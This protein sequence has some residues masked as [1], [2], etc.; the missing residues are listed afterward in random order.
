MGGAAFRQCRRIFSCSC[1]AADEMPALVQGLLGPWCVCS[2]VLRPRP[3]LELGTL[4]AV[5][6]GAAH[7]RVTARL[8]LGSG[9]SPRLPHD[10]KNRL[11]TT[12]C[13]P[14][15]I[16]TSRQRPARRTASRLMAPGCGNAV[17]LSIRSTAAQPRCFKPAALATRE[18]RMPDA[19]KLPQRL[20]V[21]SGP[22]RRSY[23]TAA[24]SIARYCPG[25]APP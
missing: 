11:E 7:G 23:Y 1:P 17:Y 4:I 8:G 15:C 20:P 14:V 3:S 6:D 22:K 2:V 19:C 18:R 13:L 12:R 21:V 16:T 24:I 25:T 9:H 10:F 5:D